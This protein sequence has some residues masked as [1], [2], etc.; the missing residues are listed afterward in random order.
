MRDVLGRSNTRPARALH[1]TGT[2]AACIPTRRVRLADTRA[3][4]ELCDHAGTS[5]T[6]CACTPTRGC[7]VYGARTRRLRES[8]VLGRLW[9][10]PHGRPAGRVEC[11]RSSSAVDAVQDVSNEH[12][13]EMAYRRPCGVPAGFDVVLRAAGVATSR[14]RAVGKTWMGRG[15]RK[16][17]GGKVGVS[18]VIRHGIRDVRCLFGLHY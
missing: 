6:F 18:F 3:V 9:C 8:A 11:A 13:A 7:T 12:D 2:C 15:R 17:V 5:S 16:E 1:H 14:G 4:S 10:T